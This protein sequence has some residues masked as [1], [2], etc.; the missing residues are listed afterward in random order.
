MAP[1]PA[2]SGT[3]LTVDVGAAVTPD[4][5]PPY[6]AL[7]RPANTT[8]TGANAETV[9]VTAA[10]DGTRQAAVTIEVVQDGFAGQGAV[11][12]TTTQSG[13]GGSNE[14][15][16]IVVEGDGGTYTLSSPGCD[17][18][19]ARLERDGRRHRSGTQRAGDDLGATPPS[20]SPPSRTAALVPTRNSRSS[21]PPPVA[22]TRSPSTAP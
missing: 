7:V 15:Q 22:P 5:T 4:L 16:A 9:L 10:V 2:T 19:G 13:G 3:T 6:Y 1:S 18:D 8:E 21:S 20:R 11:T 14:T 17:H 12:V